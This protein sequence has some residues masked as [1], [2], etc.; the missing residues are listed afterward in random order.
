M[1]CCFFSPAREEKPNPTP[2]ISVNAPIHLE[3]CAHKLKRGLNRIY[4][5]KFYLQCR[6]DIHLAK[7]DVLKTIRVP[8]L[9]SLHDFDNLYTAPAGGFSDREDYYQSCSTYQLLEKIETPT[10]A[11]TAKDDPFVPFESYEGA[12]LSKNVHLHAE[13]T[14]GHMGYL[15]RT[16]LP[17]RNAPLAGLC[18][19]RIAAHDLGDRP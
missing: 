10:I 6:R 5:I 16:P 1:R 12:V 15:T 18:F 11:I 19:V 4:D 7:N 9:M 17:L 2:A 8:W 3:K 14:G 13:D